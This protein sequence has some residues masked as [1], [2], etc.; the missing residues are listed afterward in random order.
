[1]LFPTPKPQNRLINGNANERIIELSVST[2][3][4]NHKPNKTDILSLQFARQSLSLAE[5]EQKIRNGF[6]FCHCFNIESPFG[7]NMKKAQN[8]ECTNVV[9]L[10]VD[11]QGISMWDFIERA[12]IKPTV[13]YTTASDNPDQQL[14]CF[15]LCYVFKENISTQSQ[16]K[17]LCKAITSMLKQDIPQIVFDSHGFTVAQY[18]NGNGSG[19][20]E[21]TSTSYIYSLSDFN[22]QYKESSHE[23]KKSVEDKDFSKFITDFEFLHDF[24]SLIPLTLRDKYDRKYPFFDKSPLIQMDGYFIYPE[25]YTEIKRRKRIDSFAKSDKELILFSRLKLI[26]DGEGRRNKLYTGCLIRR[27]I[28]PDVTFEHLLMNLVMERLYYFDNSDKVLT[29]SVLMDIAYNALSVP[30][31]EINIPRYRP[32][33]FRIDKSY[34]TANGVS[35]RKQCGKIRRDRTDEMIGEYYDFN[36]SVRKNM[37]LLNDLGIKVGKT[38]LQQFVHRY[39]P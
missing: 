38:R 21:I 30:L 2:N 6:C 17:S 19:N 36:L 39:Q 12:T 14:Y 37:K 8:F 7:V 13:G 20:C 18:M 35:V 34:C 26:K 24:K 25:D 33:D 32:H 11:K 27:Q 1:M 4:F 22:L 15:R 23:E 5:F 28:K 16:Y 31:E 29:N 3:S 10:D 9:F